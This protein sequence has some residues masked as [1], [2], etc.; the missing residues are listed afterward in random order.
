MSTYS[1]IIGVTTTLL[2]YQTFF[3][4]DG[5]K[6]RLEGASFK[7]FAREEGVVI[8]A[9]TLLPDSSLWNLDKTFEPST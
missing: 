5:A 6:G 4:V 2:G 7:L 1:A 9:R 3:L 8:R